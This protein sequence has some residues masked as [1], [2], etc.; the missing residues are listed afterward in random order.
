MIFPLPGFFS[1]LRP[2]S[3]S[4]G[5]RPPRFPP[6]PAF[7]RRAG[8]PGIFSL[9]KTVFFDSSSSSGL[10]SGAGDGLRTSL[11]LKG[12]RVAGTPLACLGVFRFETFF[13]QGPL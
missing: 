6:E 1:P 10:F 12:S 2:R 4:R 3:V 11:V 5:P 9:G 13:D 8:T 7:C